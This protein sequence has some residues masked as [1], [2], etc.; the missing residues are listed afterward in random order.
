M[1]Y[2]EFYKPEN[3]VLNYNTKFS[4]ITEETLSKVEKTIKDDLHPRLKEFIRK[5]TILVG[6]SL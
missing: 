5:D 3:E 2:D 4:G 1:L 6:H